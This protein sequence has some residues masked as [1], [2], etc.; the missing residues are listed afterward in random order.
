MN[1]QSC[2][3]VLVNSICTTQTH[4]IQ[5]FVYFFLYLKSCFYMLILKINLKKLKIYFNVFMKKII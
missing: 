5:E 3:R 4:A 2:E 1:S